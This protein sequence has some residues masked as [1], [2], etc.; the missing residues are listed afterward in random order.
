[1]S[2]AE[3]IGLATCAHCGGDHDAAAHTDAGM[4]RAVMR[5]NEDA[6]DRVEAAL[7]RDVVRKLERRGDR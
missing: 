7:W 4:A 5:R 6:G 1:M 2:A 3:D